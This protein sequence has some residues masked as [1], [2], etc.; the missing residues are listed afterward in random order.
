MSD[1]ADRSY[2]TRARRLRVRVQAWLTRHAFGLSIT[3][4]LALFTLVFFWS[5]IV[6]TIHPGQAGVY[7][8]RFSGTQINVIYREGTHFIPPWN[9]LYI[10]DLR[11]AKI[12]YTVAVLA[13]DGLEISVDVTMRYRPEAR[14][15]PQLHQNI[16]PD[17]AERIIVPEVVSVVREVIGRYRP[18]QLYTLRSEDI[19]RQ[20]VARATVEARAH[21][22][23]IDDVIIRRITLPV[24]V[25]A[26]IQQKLQQEQEALE[27]DYRI[28]KEKREAERKKIEAIGI[29]DFQNAISSG[30]TPAYLQWKGIEATL[31]LAQSANAKVVIVGG[32]DGLP[33]I[34][35]TP[36]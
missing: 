33:L 6:Y 30:I 34:L 19:A 8:K 31:A 26:A 28:E 25:Q 17:Y 35:N 12:D 20:L 24:S 9:K 27:Y 14:S 36:Q 29:S 7:W 18:E 5:A 1:T 23:Q 10:Y 16:G 15:L 22:L 4:L 11:V 13:T 2:R 32:K 21:F 3:G